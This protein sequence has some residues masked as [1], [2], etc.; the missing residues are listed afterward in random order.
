MAWLKE[1]Q[2]FGTELEFR[3]LRCLESDRDARVI[4]GVKRAFDAGRRDGMSVELYVEGA[5]PH[6]FQFEGGIR[7]F[8]F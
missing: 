2:P 3:V 5:R 6:L 7:Q 1:S 8:F 4:A